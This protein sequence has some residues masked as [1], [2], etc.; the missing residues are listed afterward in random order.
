MCHHFVN[1]FNHS[2]HSVTNESMQ[3]CF[4]LF[5]FIISATLYMYDA[6]YYIKTVEIV[7][8]LG[9]GGGGGGRFLV[10][11]DNRNEHLICINRTT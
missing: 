2:F 9:G 7:S 3:S 10:K 1:L 8:I 11:E 6:W 5:R 4:R